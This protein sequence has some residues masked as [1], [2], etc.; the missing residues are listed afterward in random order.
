MTYAY[1]TTNLLDMWEQSRFNSGRVNQLFFATPVSVLKRDGDYRLV[2]EPMGYRGWAN[3]NGLTAI[4]SRDF[5]TAVKSVN[6]VATMSGGARLLTARQN[7]PVDPFFLYYG[8]RLTVTSWRSPYLTVRLPDGGTRRV[9]H[10]RIKP[11]K[12]RDAR[13]VTG[14]VLVA[15]ARRFLGVPYLWGGI[16]NAGF[17]CSGLVQTICLR[18]GIAMPRDTKDQIRVGE[19]INR[20]EIRTGDLVFFDRHV[21]FAIGN[22][23]LIHASVAGTGVRINSLSAGGAAYRADLDRTFRAARRIL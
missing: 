1:V 19:P 23:Q 3:V 8:T 16:T 15:E 5:Q 11:I 2:E 10:G 7:R 6:G 18:F 20:E 22:D 13:K 14:R 21:G 9:K 4:S 17:D 12:E